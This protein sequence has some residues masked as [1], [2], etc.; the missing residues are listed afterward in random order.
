MQKEFLSFYHAIFFEP[1]LSLRA[2][3]V[4]NYGIAYNLLDI[5]NKNMLKHQDVSDFN[6]NYLHI[7]RQINVKTIIIKAA[8][9]APIATP[10]TSPSTSHCAP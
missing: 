8:T 3:I 2:K 9:D 6:K 4:L 5:H 10:R 1:K 7:T